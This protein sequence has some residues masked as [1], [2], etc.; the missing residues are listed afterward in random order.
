MKADTRKEGVKMN[1]EYLR[2]IRKLIFLLTLILLLEG[3]AVYVRDGYY[4]HYPYYH[5]YHHHENWH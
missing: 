2:K 4:D 1:H 3:C 5:H